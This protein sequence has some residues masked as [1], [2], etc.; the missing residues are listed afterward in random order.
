[1]TPDWWGSI[2]VGQVVGWLACKGGT[3]DTCRPWY[4]LNIIIKAA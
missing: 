2:T 3:F 1:M 4:A